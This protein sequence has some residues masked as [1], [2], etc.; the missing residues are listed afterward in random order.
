ML[1]VSAF[2]QT[3]KPQSVP[4]GSEIEVEVEHTRRGLL[5]RRVVSMRPP[6]SFIDDD[7]FVHAKVRWFNK[8]RGYGFLTRGDGTEDIFIHAVTLKA[9][10]PL[11]ELTQHMSVL[12]VVEPSTDGRP[13][14]MHVRAAP[15]EAAGT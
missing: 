14:A 6:A 9:S 10:A 2:D 8:K 15:A 5:V 7:K 1:H 12:V 11:L 4:K 13:K 3:C